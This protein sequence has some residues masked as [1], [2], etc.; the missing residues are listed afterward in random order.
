[1][2]AIGFNALRGYLNGIILGEVFWL[3]SS[4]SFPE[5]NKENVFYLNGVRKTQ[6][7]VGVLALS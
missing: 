3:G 4:V 2:L 7:L 6:N 1:M 5:S